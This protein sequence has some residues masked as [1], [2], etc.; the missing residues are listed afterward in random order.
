MRGEVGLLLGVDH[1]SPFS[2]LSPVP[3]VHAHSA[4]ALG[5]AVCHRRSWHCRE[6]SCLPLVRLMTLSYAHAARYSPV[7]ANV[8]AL[9]SSKF[10]VV[11]L[12]YFVF[13]SLFSQMALSHFYLT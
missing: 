10:I 1:P 2:C 6:A 3:A 9:L 7:S 8:S 12:V 13:L 4:R 5:R 11:L